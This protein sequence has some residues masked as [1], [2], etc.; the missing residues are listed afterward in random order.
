MLFRQQDSSSFVIFTKAIF[1]ERNPKIEAELIS[2]SRFV[3]CASSFMIE[4]FSSRRGKVTGKP[5]LQASSFSL[6]T[7]TCQTF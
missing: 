3:V 1:F 4:L 6:I 7:I 5:E 2:R